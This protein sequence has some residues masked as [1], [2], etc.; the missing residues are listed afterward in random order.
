M[1]FRNARALLV[2]GISVLVALMSAGPAHAILAVPERGMVTNGK[3]NALAQA[4]GLVFAGGSFTEAG[5]RTGPTARIA[6]SSGLADLAQPDVAGGTVHVVVPD[7]SGGV[8]IGGSFNAVERVRRPGIAHLKADGT[9]DPGFAPEVL[10]TVRAV[11][12]RPQG[13]FIGGDFE[14]VNGA[15]RRRLAAVGY[16][17]TVLPFAPQPDGEVLAMATDGSSLYVGGR[18]AVIAGQPRPRLAAFSLLTEEIRPAFAPRPDGEVSVLRFADGRLYAA[19]PFTVIGGQRRRHVA[20]LA[21]DGGVSWFR[22]DPSDRVHAIEPAGATVYLGGSFRFAAG[23]PSAHIAA[24]RAD[25]G[26][27]TLATLFLGADADVLTLTKV[28]GTLYAGGTFTRLAG[29]ERR[30][31][32]AIDLASRHATAWNPRAMGAVRSLARVGDNVIAGGGFNAMN[33]VL[34]T[35]LLAMD[36]I[37]RTVSPLVPPAPDGPVLAMAPHG[38]KLLL[39]GTFKRLGWS[40]RSNLAELRVADA[41]LTALRTPVNGPVRALAVAGGSAYLGGDFSKVGAHARQNLARVAAVDGAVQPFGAGADGTVR[42]LIVHQGR[43]FAGG[44]FARAGGASSARLAALNLASGTALGATP[45]IG[46]GSVHALVGASD[47]STVYIGGDFTS[48]AGAS[49]RRLAEFRVADGTLTQYDA[50]VAS[51]VVRALAVTPRDLYLGGT[52]IDVT[53]RARFNLAS[54]VR[55]THI[56]GARFFPQ[57]NGTVNALLSEPDTSILAGGEFTTTAFTNASGFALFDGPRQ[58]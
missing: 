6:A 38:D 19:G 2:L 58:E 22:P 13:I 31:I 23:V 57:P 52:F 28:G 16:D 25:T 21:P 40:L 56:T 14:S 44:S 50:Y 39:G 54:S 10:G 29:A 3:I 49:H 37:S 36:R 41:S 8:Y 32:G 51:G 46:D 1:R 11:V 42:A 53:G 12:L 47:T 35:N 18:F 33:T 5:P 55:T 48:V 43:L 30:R 4:G 26:G 7:G 17:G 24:V 9:L 34:R 45:A 20:A 27:P 15:P